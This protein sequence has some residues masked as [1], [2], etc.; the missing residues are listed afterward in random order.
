MARHAS[1][2]C[3]HQSRFQSS[4]NDGVRQTLTVIS[5]APTSSDFENNSAKLPAPINEFL[6]SIFFDPGSW[7]LLAVS[8]PGEKALALS[9]G[10]LRDFHA[11]ARFRF[12]SQR[13]SH[14]PDNT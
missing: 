3:G 8:F 1:M 13:F 5:A 6:I 9:R 2:L 7:D 12:G 4:S 14:P 11:G 10:S